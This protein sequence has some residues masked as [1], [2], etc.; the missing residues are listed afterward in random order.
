MQ[1]FFY[2]L[3]A[4]FL[5]GI[6]L[7]STQCKNKEYDLS[8]GINKEIE[9]GGDNLLF[10]IGTTDTLRLNIFLNPEDISLL[11]VLEDGSY[12]FLMADSMDVAVPPLNPSDFSMNDVVIENHIS[13]P[14]RLDNNPS[15][16]Q[17][18]AITGTLTLDISDSNKLHL[19]QNNFP[20]EV[21]S[22]DSLSL[23]NG[24]FEITIDIQNAPDLGAPFYTNLRIDLPDNM[25]FGS[26]VP[27]LPGN[28]LEIKQNLVNNKLSISLD[29]LSC[30]FDGKPLNGI[31]DFTG[32]LSYTGKI[33]ITPSSGIDISQ[34]IGQVVDIN[35]DAKLTNL[36]FNKVYGVLDP[37]IPVQNIGVSLASLPEFLRS[38]NVVLDFSNPH[39]DLISKS[40]LGI[41]MNA[42]ITINP[43]LNGTIVTAGIQNV[44]IKLPSSSSPSQT[45]T[46]KYWIADNAEG[47]PEGYVLK[48]TPL[49]NLLLKLPDS[50]QLRVDAQADK[51]KQHYV[52]I[53]A[54]YKTKV[55]YKFLVPIAFGNEFKLSLADTIVNLPSIIGD[56]AQGGNITVYG[57]V[58][59]TLPIDLELA[60]IPIDSTYTVIP[61]DI[62]PQIIK[63]GT[64]SGGEVSTN[65]NLQIDDPDKL[66]KK[67]YGFILRFGAT[68]G[69]NTEGVTIKESSYVRARLKLRLIGGINIKL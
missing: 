55:N 54:S 40:N 7:L 6:C 57:D 9:V 36:E 52:E 62:K 68:T 24:K 22:L 63:A 66:M 26:R 11:T 65:L 64:R 32:K 67:A 25:R 45:A 35:I 38:D 3:C 12:A 8:E 58:I 59:N 14:L 16:F 29:V 2:K 18:A 27:L 19:E 13:V 50:L 43:W 1:K 17:K 4:V 69:S 46:V 53:G 51:N 30:L 39:L 60:L 21:Y 44:A 33:S 56:I 5:L 15:S 37:Q 41:P 10:P 47:M 28:V 42:D 34:S 31:F 61:V 20:S 23:S 49:S 48:Q